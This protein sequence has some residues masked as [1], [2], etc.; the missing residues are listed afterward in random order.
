MRDPE[1]QPD[2]MAAS[3]I[4]REFMRRSYELARSAAAGGSR[5]FGALLVA[6]GRVIAERGNTVMTT[7]DRTLHAELRLVSLA[8]RRFSDDLLSACVLY[9]ST[10]PCLMCCGAIY[11][12]RIPRVVYGT[13]DSQL[14]A[15]LGSDYQGIPAREAFGRIAPNVEIIGPVL[16]QEGLA[17]HRQYWLGG[18]DAGRQS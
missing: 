15:L 12:A 6:D 11:W 16:E 13:T 9:A 2:D 1:P 3:D 4:D 5:P 10:E 7:R 8:S 14:D 18:S 17:V